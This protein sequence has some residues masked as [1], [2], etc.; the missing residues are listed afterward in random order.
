M[1]VL[2]SFPEG[3]ATTNPY[4]LQL[5]RALAPS[6][7]VFGFTWRRALTGRYDVFHVHWPEILLQGR[8]P[9]RALAKR[10]LFRLL[11]ARLRLRRTAVVRTLHNVR[12]HEA[13]PRRDRRLLHAFDH[14]TTLW[15]RLNPFTP[16]P[17]G[18][19]ERT[20]P[21]GDY[22]DWYSNRT[23]AAP[24]SGRLLYFGL[25]RAYK[26]VDGLVETFR[27]FPGEVESSL[28]IVGAPQSNERAQRLLRAAAGDRRI[29]LLLRHASDAEL[30][31]AIG[32]AE[33]VVLPYAE[34]HNS[35]AALLALSLDRPVL[36][37]TNAVTAALAGEVG[38]DWVLTY[39]GPLS[40]KV[41]ADALDRVRRPRSAP[42]LTH[43]RWS[44]SASDHVEAYG[45]AVQA[46]RAR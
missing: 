14:R 46:V 5:S 30:S 38:P 40:A 16:V 18:A 41:L 28:R 2:Q 24:I 3:R 26:G 23:S 33:L 4:L 9:G 1:R 37:P 17:E 36:V 44:V 31:D 35:G 8:T 45:R 12:S 43:R 22:R 7:E 27:Q 6:V 29:E 34:M 39:D 20:I 10:M 21:H 32:A 42:D 13:A 15:I 25:I 11:L 19:L